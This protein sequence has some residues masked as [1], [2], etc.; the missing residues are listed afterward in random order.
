MINKR[1]FTC[2]ALLALVVVFL[3]SGCEINIQPGGYKI[4]GR[5]TKVNSD[6]Q[7]APVPGV[8]IYYQINS[9]YTRSVPAKTDGI[10]EI[11]ANRGDSLTIWAEKDNYRFRQAPEKFTVTDNRSDV[12]FEVSGWQDDFSNTGSGW[13]P[14]YYNSNAYLIEV[15]SSSSSI[16]T[17]AP[18]AVPTSYNVEATMTPGMGSGMYGLVF[19]ID[20]LNTVGDFYYI[21]RV[22]PELGYCQLSKARIEEIIEPGK[23]QTYVD[24]I[25]TLYNDQIDNTSTTITNG[26]NILKVEQDWNQVKLFIYNVCV[27]SGY[28]DVQSNDVL[29]VGLYAMRNDTEYSYSAWFDDFD[30]TAVGFRELPKFRSL[31]LGES[32]THKDVEITK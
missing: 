8:T 7:I 31:S 24:D 29:K 1:R 20:Q 9:S 12:N 19:N 4:S 27:W 13:D 25:V 14:E 6:D 28:I 23:A 5:V 21:F 3:L 32:M 2:F 11:Y 26:T 18:L 10:W 22:N 15:P 16:K 30:L 17:I